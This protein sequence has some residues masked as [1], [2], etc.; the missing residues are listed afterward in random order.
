VQLRTYP[1]CISCLD[2]LRFFWA[3]TSSW[4]VQLAAFCEP[5]NEVLSRREKKGGTYQV[6]S[7]WSIHPLHIPALVHAAAVM[8]GS[9]DEES[10]Q[11]VKT[12]DL[13]VRALENEGIN[14]IFGE[15]PQ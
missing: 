13:F 12:S 14:Y 3:E 4:E 15:L 1:V 5:E 11:P 9:G 7:L 2:F 6:I 10:R 8:P